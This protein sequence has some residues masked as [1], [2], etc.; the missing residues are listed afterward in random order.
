MYYTGLT[1]QS[2]YQGQQAGAYVPASSYGQLSSAP[3]VANPQSGAISRMNSMQP[4]TPSFS[5][6]P[7]EVIQNIGSYNTMLGGTS[8]GN[9]I[10]NAGL[11]RYNQFEQQY[12]Q[13]SLPWYMR[14]QSAGGYGGS[15]YD[16]NLFLGDPGQIGAG[17]TYG[18]DFMARENMRDPMTGMILGY[19]QE[20]SFNPVQEGFWNTPSPTIGRTGGQS[21]PI[22]LGFIQNNPRTGVAGSQ[23]VYG[24]ID[25]G[26]D[27]RI[28]GMQR[29]EMGQW[30]IWNAGD[31]WNTR[32]AQMAEP[33]DRNSEAWANWWRHQVSSGQAGSTPEQI[34]QGFTNA[35]TR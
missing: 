22:K 24:S 19:G 5:K 21:G 2:P 13:G 23:G 25:R 14:D 30:D 8:A 28:A 26:F 17:Y 29:P 20:R 12:G 7:S 18:Q 1:A 10:N 4:I 15:V 16:R 11:N 9:M 27:N 31:D 6:A 33:A 35:R 32:A 34:R 3:E